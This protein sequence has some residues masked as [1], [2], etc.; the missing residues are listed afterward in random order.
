MGWLVRLVTG[1]HWWYGPPTVLE[2]LV[3]NFSV[4]L[5]LLSNCYII[6]T[7]RVTHLVWPHQPE[8]PPGRPI[9]LGGS[10]HEEAHPCFPYLVQPS[11]K[12]IDAGS[13]YHPLVQ[14]ISSINHSVWKKYL[15]QSRVHRNLTSFLECPLIPL[16]LSARV[17]NSFNFNLD[18]P[19][20]ILKTSMNPAYFFALQV[21]IASNSI[22]F[23]H[24][25]SRPYY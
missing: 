10:V 20:H 8:N 1:A 4:C 5:V 11:F 24:T 17:K 13:M 25:I 2:F 7:H 15:Q 16:V 18:S 9:G 3:I 19:L 21:S 23:L 14:L 22:I 6:I 12:G